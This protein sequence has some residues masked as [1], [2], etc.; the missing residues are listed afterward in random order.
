[1][2][3]I[4]PKE[5]SLNKLTNDVID[6]YMGQYEK[7]WNDCIDSILE[8][9]QRIEAEPVRHGR[10]VHDDLGHTY[11]SECHERI[12]YIHFYS[13]EPNSD[14]DEEWDEEMPESAYCSHC[15]AKM[16]G[17]VGNAK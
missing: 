4:N 5:I 7:G 17:G 11:C 1:M 10:W 2:W 12:P 8:D 14:W 16:D 3:L 6:R 13:D 15:G 9:I